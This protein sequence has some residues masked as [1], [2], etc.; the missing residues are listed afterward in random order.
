MTDRELAD[1]SS[2]CPFRATVALRL[3]CRHC[4]TVLRT[5]FRSCTLNSQ[6]V[7]ISV[8]ALTLSLFRHSLR[9]LD[10]EMSSFLCLFCEQMKICIVAL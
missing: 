1:C 2:I 9:S 6:N 4:L 8:K 10:K 7:I 5:V 3:I